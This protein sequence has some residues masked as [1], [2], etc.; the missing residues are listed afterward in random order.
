MIDAASTNCAKRKIGVE[1]KK[2]EI[3]YPHI[4]PVSCLILNE[5]FWQ[6]RI[7]PTNTTSLTQR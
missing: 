4:D 3:G 2:L 7:A 5:I 1:H 6:G